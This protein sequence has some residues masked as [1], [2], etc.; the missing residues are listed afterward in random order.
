MFQS[1]VK[2]RKPRFHDTT[3]KNKIHCDWSNQ[4]RLLTICKFCNCKNGRNISFKYLSR[5]RSRYGLFDIYFKDLQSLTKWLYPNR[6]YLMKVAHNSS[7]VHQPQGIIVDWAKTN[8]HAECEFRTDKVSQGWEKYVA[9]CQRD[10]L[11][12]GSLAGRRSGFDLFVWPGLAQTT[13]LPQ[14]Q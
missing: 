13:V 14:T 9:K 12:F 2:I 4:Y 11:L 5:P 3:H 7:F 1:L 8:K 6:I 10:S